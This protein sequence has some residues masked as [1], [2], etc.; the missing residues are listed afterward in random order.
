MMPSDQPRTR[1]ALPASR[2]ARYL[3]PVRAQRTARSTRPPSSGA[4]GSMLNT[5]SSRLTAADPARGRRRQC[6]AGTEGDGT[7]RQADE[8]TRDG[9]QTVGTRGRWLTVEPGDAAECPQVDRLGLDAV[10]AGDEGM[11]ELVGEDRE[12]E[13]DHGD[14]AGND[15]EPSGQADAE[16]HGDERHAPVRTH[17]DAE[18]APEM[19]RTV[20][21]DGY[22]RR[23]SV[24]IPARGACNSRPV[25]D[26]GSSHGR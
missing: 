23:T 7:D 5:A 4:P 8:R 16:Q 15:A 25:V 26:P 21:H 19:Q 24:P 14:D 17:R 1:P 22:N 9:D 6:E 13:G 3:L 20:A 12:E 18:V 2:I 10:A 11:A